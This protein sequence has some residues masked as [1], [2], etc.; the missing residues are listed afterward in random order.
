MRLTPASGLHLPEQGE[1]LVPVGVGLL[2]E[3]GRSEL[4]V[5]KP[6]LQAF[7]RLWEHPAP[8]PRPWAVRRR[9][10]SDWV[11]AAASDQLRSRLPPT[12]NRPGHGGRSAMMFVM[13]PNRVAAGLGIPVFVLGLVVVPDGFAWATVP[14]VVVALLALVG[15]FA[16]VLPGVRRLP[17]VGAQR[18]KAADIDGE[19]ATAPRASENPAFGAQ[20]S[21]SLGYRLILREPWDPKPTDFGLFT[22]ARLRITNRQND[23]P[24]SIDVRLHLSMEVTRTSQPLA[25]RNLKDQVEIPEDFLAPNT[26]T[27]PIHVGPAQ[28]VIGDV[29]FLMPNA[30]RIASTESFSSATVEIIDY[31][32]DKILM[33][34]IG[35][36]RPSTPEPL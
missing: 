21:G 25:E 15:F 23:T 20:T 4:V 8:S 2:G 28:T 11:T 30:G 5:L 22:V 31:V 32:S 3:R 27:C 10:G 7:L 16:P 26:L 24:L 36:R 14:L 19:P 6:L 29:T 13:S 9:S 35:E 12:R 34:G 17:L 18:P 1:H 33:L